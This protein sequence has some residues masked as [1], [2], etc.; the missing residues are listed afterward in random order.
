[1]HSQCGFIY[2]AVCD[3]PLLRESACISALKTV[4]VEEYHLRAAE[5]GWRERERKTPESLDQDL[6]RLRFTSLQHE[7]LRLRL[8][9]PELD[10]ESE[11]KFEEK[12]ALS[13]SK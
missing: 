7:L 13:K 6:L 9:S 1:M 10:S 8:L 12:E 2:P 5:R 4:T 3:S 11:S